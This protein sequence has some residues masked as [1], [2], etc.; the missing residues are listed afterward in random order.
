M[1]EDWCDIEEIEQ[2]DKKISIHD[3]GKARWEG[4]Q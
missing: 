4:T 3:Y 2:V 1:F